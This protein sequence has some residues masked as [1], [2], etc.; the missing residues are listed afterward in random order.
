MF[1]INLKVSNFQSQ[2]P[3]TR[4]HSLKI[5]M[6]LF[7]INTSAYHF[8]L[9]AVAFPPMFSRFFLIIVLFLFTSTT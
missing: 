9:L 8:G 7:V 4:G 3:P 2:I 1:E 5:Y 6:K